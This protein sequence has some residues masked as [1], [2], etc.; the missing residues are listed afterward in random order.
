MQQETA[1]DVRQPLRSPCLPPM[2]SVLQAVSECCHTTP[3]HPA[4]LHSLLVSRQ[5]AESRLLKQAR[6]DLL[7][8]NDIGRIVFMASDA[9]IELSSL[10]I[11][12]RCG[13]GLQTFPDGIQQLCFLSRRQALNLASQIG[14]SSITL[15]RFVPGCKSSV[16]GPVSSGSPRS[17]RCPGRHRCRRCQV[18]ISFC[19]GGVRTKV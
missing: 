4:N 10:S 15:A 2:Q 6:F 14:H 1:R 9:V 7:P 16:R 17:W 11:S 5:P 19:G 8:G 13:I 18:R 12:Q 3:G